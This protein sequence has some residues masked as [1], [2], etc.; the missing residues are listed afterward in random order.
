MGALDGKIAVITGG[1]TGIGLAIAERFANEGAEVVIAGRRQQR[2]EDAAAQLGH[3]VRGVVTDV[4]DDAQVKRLIDSVPRVDLLVTCAGGAVFGA[5]ETVPSKAW[6]ELFN[7]RFFGQLSACHYAVPKMDAG[8]A[9]ILCSGIA[10]HAALVNYSG[11]AGLCGAVNAMGRSLSVELAPRG[12][13][14]NVL[15]PGL[16]R[17]TAIDWGVPPEQLGA[18]MDSL[19]SNIPLK[20]PGTVRDMADAAYFLATCSYATGQVIDIDGGWT[21]V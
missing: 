6:R 17:D 1:G 4:G 9:I 7:D 10:G 11:G 18:F 12:I 3:G 5:V 8:S 16:T 14:V 13:R 2:L 20:R 19:V 21:A 15:S